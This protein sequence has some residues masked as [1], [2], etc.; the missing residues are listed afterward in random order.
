MVGDDPRAD[1]LGLLL[2]LLH[3]PGALDDV[4]EARIVLD[5]GGDGELAAG[6]DALDQHRLQHGARGIDGGGVAGRAGADDDKLGVGRL[7]HA[8]PLVCGHDRVPG[9]RRG[10]R[11]AGQPVRPAQC[12][13]FG[14]AMQDTQPDELHDTSRSRRNAGPS[15]S[16]AQ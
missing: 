2:H 12:K 11:R 9:A 16:S 6:L 1:V 14:R 13:C 7:G 4:G 5:V 8:H 3:Q 15:D 10:D